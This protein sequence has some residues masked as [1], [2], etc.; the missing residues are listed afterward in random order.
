MF[1]REVVTSKK[2]YKKVMADIEKC[3]GIITSQTKTKNGYIDIDFYFT[4]FKDVVRFDD[5]Y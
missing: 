2:F 3:N 5:L 4:A 1:E